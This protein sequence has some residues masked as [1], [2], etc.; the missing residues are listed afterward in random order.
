[1][2]QSLYFVKIITQYKGGSIIK[3]IYHWGIVTTNR[4]KADTIFT[5]I[6]KQY[7]NHI[8]KRTCSRYFRST[9]FDDGNYLEWVNPIYPLRGHRYHRVWV[10]RDI[11]KEILDY[12]IFPILYC[13]ATA[14]IWI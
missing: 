9:L 5:K 7:E 13:S 11:D 8:V 1:M 14:V 12:R 6:E 10:D 2:L 3:L 4:D